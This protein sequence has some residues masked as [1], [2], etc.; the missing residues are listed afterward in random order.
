MSGFKFNKVY[1]LESLDGSVEKLT[2]TELHDDL[3][4]RKAYQIEDFK[5]E[6]L[7]ISSKEDFFDK[8]EEIKNDCVKEGYYPILH[9]EMHGSTDETGLVLVSGEL[10]T[11]EELARELRELNLVIENNL[12]ITMAVCFGAFLM[13]L[14]KVNESAPFWGIIGSFEIIYVYDLL[15]RYNEFYTEFLESFDLNKAIDKLHAANPSLESPFQFINS[16]QTF[17]NVNKK[18]FSEKFSKQAIKNRFED[19]IK[20]EGIRIKDRNQMHEFRL[21]FTAQLHKTKRITFEEHKNIFFMINE[22]P[23]NSERFKVNYEDLQ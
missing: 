11:W 16:E 19:G 12:F 17:I 13:K 5:T 10:V 22:F 7:S 23:G 1:V 3:L 18:Y 14:I 15:L 20:E 8:L 2:G 4:K 6:L 21:N 9:L